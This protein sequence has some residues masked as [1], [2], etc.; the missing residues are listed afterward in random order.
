MKTGYDDLRDSEGDCSGSP[1]NV[2]AEGLPDAGGDDEARQTT[3][4][5]DAPVERMP[6]L[7]AVGVEREVEPSGRGRFFTIDPDIWPV[8]CSLGM[9]AA[10]NYL[11]LACGT[12]RDMLHTTWSVHA[13]EKYPPSPA[14][15]PARPCRR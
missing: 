12:G 5:R 7:E 10:V 3:R 8:V 9:N 15:A 1:R 11:V 4:A 2:L 13:V 6:D 14:S